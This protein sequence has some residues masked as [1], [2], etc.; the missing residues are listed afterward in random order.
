MSIDAYV[1]HSSFEQKEK[2]SWLKIPE[3]NKLPVYTMSITARVGDDNVIRFTQDVYK[4]N[5]A[6]LAALQN[7]GYLK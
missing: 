6:L 5:A 7:A 2:E 1:P 4:Q 3:S